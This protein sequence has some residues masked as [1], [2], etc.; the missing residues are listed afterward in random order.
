MQSSADVRY[1]FKVYYE[2]SGNCTTAI[3][4]GESDR[5]RGSWERDDVTA[6]TSRKKN[7]LLESVATVLHRWTARAS[8]GCEAAYF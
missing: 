8:S 1:A 6:L 3:V 2:S 4:A 5:S 7:N